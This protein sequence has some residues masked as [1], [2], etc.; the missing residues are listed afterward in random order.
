VR[1]VL[2]GVMASAYL[3]SDDGRYG[4]KRSLAPNQL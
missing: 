1:R 2:A 3:V 4:A